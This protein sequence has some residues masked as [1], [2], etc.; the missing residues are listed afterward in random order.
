MVYGSEMWVVN[1]EQM[2]YLSGPIGE[3]CAMDVQRIEL[4]NEVVGRN[5][6][7]WWRCALWKDDGGWVKRSVMYEV[8]S[9]DDM[10]SVGGLNKVDA[11]YHVKWRNKC[12]NPPLE[13]FVRWKN[14]CH[15]HVCMYMCL[16]VIFCFIPSTYSIK[17]L[18]CPEEFLW[19]DFLITHILVGY[20][21][22]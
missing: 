5:R 14:E 7:R 15:M 11:Q 8:D 9:E 1:T 2:D 12:G 22:I 20:L 10:E 3:C 13:P 6:A 16:C 18:S 21:P 17:H 19:E 4:A